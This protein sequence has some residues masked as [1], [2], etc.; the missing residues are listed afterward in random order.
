MNQSELKVTKVYF[1]HM[2]AY[3]SESRSFQFSCF[4]CDGKN[5]NSFGPRRSIMDSFHLTS[6]E[7]RY[8]NWTQRISDLGWQLK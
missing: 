8:E 1:Y 7:H 2:Q 4:T 5:T 3:E 6:C